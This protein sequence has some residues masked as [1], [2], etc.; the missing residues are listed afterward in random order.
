[1]T[2]WTS[3]PLRDSSHTKLLLHGLSALYQVRRTSWNYFSGKI[4][5]SSQKGN[6]PW[7]NFQ[8]CS[9]MFCFSVKQMEQIAAQLLTWKLFQL[10][11]VVAKSQINQSL[12]RGKL[13][14]TSILFGFQSARL[15]HLWL[16]SREG[17]VPQPSAFLA[18]AQHISTQQG[19]R[20]RWASPAAATGTVGTKPILLVHPSPVET[21]S[22]FHLAPTTKTLQV[23]NGKPSP[24]GC[25]DFWH[26]FCSFH[27][28]FIHFVGVLFGFFFLMQRLSF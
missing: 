23:S 25:F 20:G 16:S 10:C 24:W 15:P 8:F 13:T 6:F 5:L 17:I 4:T 14:A 26:P 21:A 9:K 19:G 22:W 27:L 12:P 2:L 3:I 28:C 18:P 11:F 7:E 1:M